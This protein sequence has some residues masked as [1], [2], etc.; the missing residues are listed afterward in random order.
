MHNTILDKN[1]T[2]TKKKD[3]WILEHSEKYFVVSD[4]IKL[5]IEILK[6]NNSDINEAYNDFIEQF[7]H[8]SKEEFNQ[9]IEQNLINLELDREHIENNKKE[10]S[11]ILFETK[12]LSNESSAKLSK[13]IQ[14]LYHP[15]FFWISFTI[16]ISLSIYN[17]FST[18]Q[19]HLE[20]KYIF[21]LFF[22]YI[23]TALI[24]EIGHIAACNRFTKKNGEIGI[25]VYFI[26][27][28]FYSNITSIWTATKQQRII[29]NLAGVYIQLYIIAFFYL[30]S[31]LTGNL[32]IQAIVVISSIIILYQLIPF[33]RTDGYWILSDITNSP[34]LLANSSKQLYSFIKN[35]L[36]YKLANKKTL[37]ELTY[38]L[39]NQLFMLYI[40]INILINYN[41]KLIKFPIELIKTI[42]N[43]PNQIFEYVNN[44]FQLILITIIFYMIVFNQIKRIIPNKDKTEQN[45]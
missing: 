44:N 35:P 45:H 12:I 4:E 17:I 22:T 31:L 10:K 34:N 1:I 3:N 14:P 25:G 41:T 29:T 20:K 32:Q 28:V 16:L 36:K 30:Y 37:L 26:F 8:V 13:L 38:G 42:I 19:I 43:Q 27:P 15:T 23:I 5:L 39:L 21:L 33:I 9:I 6:K 24:H 40:V 18:K 2:F 7:E 11:F